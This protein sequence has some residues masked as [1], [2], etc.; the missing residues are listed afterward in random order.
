MYRY[1]LNLHLPYS[2]H[3]VYSVHRAY[4]ALAAAEGCIGDDRV[5]SPEYLTL[6]KT[7]LYLGANIG[8]LS[9]FQVEIW[10]IALVS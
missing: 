4:A 10:L 3:R 7:T 2:R 1:Q 9:H 5:E 8:M 6:L